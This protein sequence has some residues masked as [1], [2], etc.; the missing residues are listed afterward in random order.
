MYHTEV[1]VKSYTNY[2]LTGFVHLIINSHTLYREI[3]F[4]YRD[5]VSNG[6]GISSEPH[7]SL[8]I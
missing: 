6:L 4:L 2:H 5:I 7:Q 3:N 8:K 1:S